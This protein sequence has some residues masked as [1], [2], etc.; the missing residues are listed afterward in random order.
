[1]ISSAPLM[2]GSSIGS[3]GDAGVSSRGSGEVGEVA[4]A[5]YCREQG[6]LH[7]SRGVDT[8]MNTVLF[9]TARGGRSEYG[10]LGRVTVR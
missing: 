1:M 10:R 7:G 2:D 9:D 3:K 6:S 4:T 8:S 5:A